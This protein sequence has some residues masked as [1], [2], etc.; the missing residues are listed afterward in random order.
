MIQ[1]YKILMNR[2]LKISMI[3]QSSVS[4]MHLFK[5]FSDSVYLILNNFFFFIEV[6]LLEGSTRPVT[7][8]VISLLKFSDTDFELGAILTSGT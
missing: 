4:V 7:E 1:Y 6:K 2:H 5:N 8:V 3:P